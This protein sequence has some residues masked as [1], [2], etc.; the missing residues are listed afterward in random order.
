MTSRQTV[1]YVREKGYECVLGNHE[2]MMMTYSSVFLEDYSKKSISD[3]L[4]NWFY[5]GGK[6]TLYSYK[7]IEIVDNQVIFTSNNEYF[8][9]YISD[10]NWM[11]TL[12]LYIELDEKVNDKKVVISHSCISNVWN[13]KDDK[14]FKKLYLGQ[15][16]WDRQTPDE[17][18]NIFNIF[19]HTKVKQAKLQ[20]NYINIDTGCH[21][22]NEDY[23]K[24]T[25]FCI[26]DSE[27]ITIK[28]DVKD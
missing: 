20:D 2:L 6:E 21:Y 17:Y 28:R 9:D 18:S 11:K 23:G 16:I 25:A 5:V 3:E 4:S 13:K 12:P 24:L 7:L 14:E 15:I 26:D 8:D 1:K 22:K 19:G 10:L 27:V